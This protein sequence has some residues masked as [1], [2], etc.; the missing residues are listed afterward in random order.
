MENFT[1]V[2]KL[3]KPK[4]DADLTKFYN[5]KKYDSGWVNRSCNFQMKINNQ[6]LYL[7]AKGGKFDDDSKTKVYTFFT[8]EGGK[9][10]KKQIPFAKRKDKKVVEKVCDWAKYV[11]DLSTGDT[12]KKYEYISAWDFVEMINRLIIS[13]KYDDAIFRVTGN[14]NRSYSSDKGRWYSN[15][16][17]KKITLVN[18]KDATQYAHST[19]ELFFDKNSLEEVVIDED[20]NTV[21][22]YV[23]Y[24][25]SQDKEQKY[26]PYVLTVRKDLEAEN[27]DLAKRK[28]DVVQRKFFKV[29]DEKVY[30]IGA[31]VEIFNGSHKVEL[32]YDELDEETRENIELGIISEE[33]AIRDMSEDGNIYGE[34]VQENIFLKP[35]R[36]YT[37]GRVVVEDMK[38]EELQNITPDDI[39]LDD[40]GDLDFDDDDIFGD[41]DGLDVDT[42]DLPF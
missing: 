21:A 5:E 30:K 39:E 4:P 12:T 17:P 24:Y 20:V 40:G 8:K 41:D 34:R 18:K 15:F 36:G 29:D 2:G 11:I 27:Q 7:Q 3:V 9:H 28:F 25:D 42:D 35:A 23:Q 1:F 31:I 37:K 26:A 13:G 38:P 19:V 33:D 10:E 16:E 6:N 14:V 32:N 22:A